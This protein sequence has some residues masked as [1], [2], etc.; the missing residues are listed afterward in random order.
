MIV[1]SEV[2]L[3]GLS[4]QTWWNQIDWFLDSMSSSNVVNFSSTD[5]IDKLRSFW[6]ESIQ[7][8]TVYTHAPEGPVSR[9]CH[10]AGREKHHMSRILLNIIHKLKVIGLTTQ[11]CINQMNV[12]V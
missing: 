8:N 7:A 6:V 2:R 9:V 5:T 10:R 3:F 11:V 4:S 1:T 12:F